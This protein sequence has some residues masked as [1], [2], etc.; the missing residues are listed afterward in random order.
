M[1][2]DYA[3][4]MLCFILLLYIFKNGC[5]VASDAH[6]RPASSILCLMYELTSL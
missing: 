5:K 2:L 4:T 6:N 3:F 1:V